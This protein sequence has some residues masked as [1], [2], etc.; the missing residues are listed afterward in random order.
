MKMLRI[1][2]CRDSLMWYADMIGDLVP[3]CGQW[4]EA[5]KSLDP[6]GHLNQ[7]KFCDAEIVELNFDGTV[8]AMRVEDK[9]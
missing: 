9:K 8:T 7:V 6:A 3:Y 5:Y 1:T 2:G 4:R